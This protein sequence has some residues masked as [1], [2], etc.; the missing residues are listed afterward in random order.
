MSHTLLLN[1]NATPVSYFPLSR[2]S[3]EES[4]KLRLYKQ[5]NVIE[6]YKDWSVGSPSIRINVPSI[7]MLANMVQYNK[8]INCSREGIYLRD[9]YTCQYCERNLQKQ[10][11]LL[12]LDHVNPRANGGKSEWTNLVTSCA[13][14]NSEKAHYHKMKPKISPFEPD[15]HYILSKRKKYPI[16]VPEESWI[17]Y[18]GWND[19]DLVKIKK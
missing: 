5:V 19:R 9:D 14:C 11:S 10:I 16:Y 12:T 6:E 4:V 1:A 18:L 8:K 2:V 7:I 13:T 3:W 17:D 15:Y